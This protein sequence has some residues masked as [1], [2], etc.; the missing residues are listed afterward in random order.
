[1]RNHAKYSQSLLRFD[2]PHKFNPLPPYLESSRLNFANA[3]AI[4]L[5]YAPSMAIVENKARATMRAALKALGSG[6]AG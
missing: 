5:A 2:S 4:L 1:L 6:I 3:N